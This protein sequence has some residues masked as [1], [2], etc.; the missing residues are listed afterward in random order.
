MMVQRIRKS[1]ILQLKDFFLDKY[2]THY[3]FQ[4]SF[5]KNL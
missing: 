4:L 5:I 2:N 1:E 3:V